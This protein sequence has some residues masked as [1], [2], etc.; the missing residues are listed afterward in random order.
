MGY[1]DQW[2]STHRCAASGPAARAQTFASVQAA[3]DQMF[4]ASSSIKQIP[5]T[6]TARATGS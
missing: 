1:D 4:N 6:S 3:G 5:I 2:T